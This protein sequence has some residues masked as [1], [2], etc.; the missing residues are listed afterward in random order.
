MF[1]EKIW[2]FRTKNFRVLFEVMPEDDLDLSFDDDDSVRDGLRNGQYVAFV[3]CVTVYHNSTRIA[4]DY[5]GNCIYES[6]DEFC[7]MHR[8]HGYRKSGS[9][10]P[11]MVR[12]AI[13]KA[14]ANLRKPPIYVRPNA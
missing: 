13:A 12:E 4:V 5:L 10:F 6:A 1:A 3:A 9:Y 7:S 8:G 2:Q 11:D 14:R